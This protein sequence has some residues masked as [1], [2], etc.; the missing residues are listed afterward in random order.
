MNYVA[1]SVLMKLS[2]KPATPVDVLQS[3]KYGEDV[4]GEAADLAEWQKNEN[5]TKTNLTANGE[6]K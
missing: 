5:Q 6:T 3:K 2:A 4:I 1:K